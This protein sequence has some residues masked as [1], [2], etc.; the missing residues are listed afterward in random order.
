[1]N[2]ELENAKDK[3]ISL[4]Q[5][6][7]IIYTVLRSVSKSGLSRSI[8][9]YVVDNNKEIININYYISVLL[10]YKFDKTHFGLIGLKVK[11]GGM[12]MGFH[13]VHT[14]LRELGITGK[15]SHR[16]L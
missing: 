12:D 4:L 14:L 11:G 10:G 9:F 16:W 1:M 6:T 3:L 15:I 13:V 8:S 5:E 7:D 2:I